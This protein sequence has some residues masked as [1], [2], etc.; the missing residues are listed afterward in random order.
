MT[1]VRE[2][3]SKQGSCKGRPAKKDLQNL[4]Q[5]LGLRTESDINETIGNLWHLLTMHKA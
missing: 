5:A 3:E 2:I 1:W 4:V